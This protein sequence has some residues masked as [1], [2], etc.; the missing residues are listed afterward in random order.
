MKILLL[1]GVNMNMLGKRDHTLYGSDTLATLEQKVQAHAQSLGCQLVCAQSNIEG[2]IINKI[3]EVGFSSD[4]IVLN[5]G[6]Y[7]HTS[8]AILDAIKSVS[9]PTIEVH[10]SN[11]H[12]REEFRHH[13][14]VAPIA[15]KTY[16]GLGFEGYRK[17]IRFLC[18]GEE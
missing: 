17:A 12:Q 5:A 18:L 1:N 3:H 9:T 16:M 15:K 2:E 8:V 10:I 11:V 4:G 7:T 14:F 13:S 6:A